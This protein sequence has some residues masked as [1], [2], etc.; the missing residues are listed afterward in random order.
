MSPSEH[1][2]VSRGPGAGSGPPAVGAKTWSRSAVL[3][4]TRQRS[5]PW[6]G[7]WWWPGIGPK[8]G[9]KLGLGLGLLWATTCAANN[10]AVAQDPEASS[11]VAIK[12]GF[13]YNFARF[14]S[15]PETTWTHPG[16]PFVF[17][18]VGS[19][20]LAYALD[21]SIPGTD[22]QGRRVAV[23][24]VSSPADLAGC[25]VVFIGSAD[26][27]T[28]SLLIEAAGRQAVL[29]VGDSRDFANE[30]GMITLVLKGNTFGFEINRPVAELAGLRV[31]SKLLKLATVAQK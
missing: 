17:G 22:V 30:G 27:R 8:T 2:H 6:S 23:Q 28:L 11:E 19:D 10:P 12:A 14:V 4:P 26:R 21:E 13:L 20:S 24:R 5:W 16:D 18:I 3:R 1:G 7:S 25:Q 15:W 31:S 9:T 29:T